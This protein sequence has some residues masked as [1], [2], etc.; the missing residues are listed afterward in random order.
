LTHHDCLVLAVHPTDESSLVVELL[1]RDDGPIRAFARGARLSRRRFPSGLD[2]LTR[3]EACYAAPARGELWTL[4]SA[5]TTD[6]FLGLRRDPVAV[7]RAAYVAEL[8]RAI[9][10][11]GV[12]AGGVLDLCLQAL[13]AL[14]ESS[15]GP[16]LLRCVEVRLLAAVGELPPLDQC[17]SCGTPLDGPARVDPLHPGHT[18]CARCAPSSS[19]PLPGDVLALLLRCAAWSPGEAAAAPVPVPLSVAA[20]RFT[21]PLLRAVVGRPLHA[22]RFLA[23]VERAP[24][25]QEQDNDEGPR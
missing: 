7:G 12:S 18:W 20:G 6:A 11:A 2:L 16:G 17:A 9:L 8:A 24:A 1:S 5:D 22:A 14:C 13:T 23:Q 21:T 3:V 19:S 25:G 15:C 10:P 4:S